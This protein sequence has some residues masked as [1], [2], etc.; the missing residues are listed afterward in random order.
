MTT[1]YLV[2]HGKAAA[3]F[4]E[5][6]DPPLDKT[7]T[8]QALAMADILG[9][10]GPL[11]LIS[12]PMRRT[13]ETASALENVWG[14]PARVEP[15]VSEVPSPTEDLKARREWLTGFME[16][17]WFDPAAADLAGWRQD[18]IAAIEEIETDTVVSSHFIAINTI[19]GHLTGDDRVTHFRPDNCSITIIRRTPDGWVL[20]ERGREVETE[21]L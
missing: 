4:D 5:D 10:K 15:R 20:V 19:V 6:H 12:S 13:R 21:V 16:G 7:G 2:R 11:P 3:A 9:P 18:L 1:V 14:A 17:S 8:R